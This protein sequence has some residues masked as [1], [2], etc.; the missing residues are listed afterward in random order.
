MD[1]LAPTVPI[2]IVNLTILTVN[3]V[4]G[5]VVL[6]IFKHILMLNCATGLVLMQL[7]T[8]R[9]G[10]IDAYLR[11][12]GFIATWTRRGAH[13]LVPTIRVISRLHWIII[14]NLE[15]IGRADRGLYSKLFFTFLVCSVPIT[16]NLIYWTLLTAETPFQGVALSAFTFFFSI[17]LFGVHHELA[18]Y[19]TKIHAPAKVLYSFLTQTIWVEGLLKKNEQQENEEENRVQVI[20]QDLELQDVPENG[21]WDVNEEVVFRADQEDS[22]SGTSSNHQ[23][24]RN[25]VQNAYQEEEEEERRRK[26]E[27]DEEW[28]RLQRIYTLRYNAVAPLTPAPRT[29]S[30]QRGRKRISA[31][32]DPYPQK[33][34]YKNIPLHARL[35]LSWMVTT[36]GT[37][38]SYGSTYGPLGTTVTH[39]TVHKFIILFCKLM[40]NTFKMHIKYA[41]RNAFR[42]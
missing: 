23:N 1:E 25:N 17:G 24:R 38:H 12:K 4:I 27:E 13:K 6:I 31:S 11:L 42:C 32:L 28:R 41:A 9:M 15:Y 14:T 26:A 19:G 34:L 40:L 2:F 29:T 37:T 8:L 39:L 20:E 21:D 16:L 36:L 10:Q 18:N 5:L 35:K 33:R 30:S 3:T 22:V 7:A